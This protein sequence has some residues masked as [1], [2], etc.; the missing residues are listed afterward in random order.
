MFGICFMFLEMSL[1]TYWKFFLYSDYQEYCALLQYINFV[2][3]KLFT[4]VY[5]DTVMFSLRKNMLGFAPQDIGWVHVSGKSSEESQCI[6]QFS[7]KSATATVLMRMP[8]C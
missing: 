6:D 1:C 2:T 3:S 8:E 4:V 7:V 5:I